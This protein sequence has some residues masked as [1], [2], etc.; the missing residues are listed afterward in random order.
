MRESGRFAAAGVFA[1]NRAGLL[2]AAVVV[3]LVLAAGFA[4]YL[5]PYQPLRGV[6]PAMLGPGAAGHLFGTDDLGR[7]VASQILY[8]LRVSIIVGGLSTAIAVA[9]GVS[10]GAIAGFAGGWLDD[11]LMRVSEAFQVIPRFFLAILLIALFGQN[12]LVTTLAIAILSWPPVARV[13]RVEFLAKRNAE[14]VLA[15]SAAGAG[16]AHLM[17]RET[18]PTLWPRSS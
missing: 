18:C 5:T 13:A 11:I 9:I 3:L 14:Y 2:G 12:L 4:S 6:A 17:L 8:G 7:D 10:V 16:A 1:A 15:A